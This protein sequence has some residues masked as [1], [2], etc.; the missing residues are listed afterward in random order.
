MPAVNEPR[1]EHF[2]PYSANYTQHLSMGPKFISSI[3][4]TN[5]TGEGKRKQLFSQSLLT[6]IK[7]GDL[8][9]KRILVS[10]HAFDE[11]ATRLKKKSS[12]KDAIDCVQTILSSEIFEVRGADYEEFESACETFCEYDDHD[13]AMTDFI[14]KTFT[15]NTKTSY[16]A[17]WDSHYQSFRNLDLLP[18]CDYS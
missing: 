8:A 13:G 5:P 16:L 7:D 1:L 15:E 3:F 10:Q 4:H 12:T 11:S 14:T 9:Y 6:W 17:T 2:K 18:R